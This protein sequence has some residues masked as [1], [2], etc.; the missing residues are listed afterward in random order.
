MYRFTTYERN[1]CIAPPK[2]VKQ[3]LNAR[4]DSY[5]TLLPPEQMCGIHVLNKDNRIEFLLA[6]FY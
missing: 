5:N 1:R 3:S 6:L 2:I 4:R